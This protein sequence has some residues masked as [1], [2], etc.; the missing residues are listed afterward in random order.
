MT[1]IKRNRFIFP[2]LLILF[3]IGFLSACSSN[4]E[5]DSDAS[6]DVATND[7]ENGFVEAE[8][9]QASSGEVANVEEGEQSEDLQ[10]SERMVIYNGDISIEV[11]DFNDARIHIQDEVDQLGGFVVESSVYQQGSENDRQNGMLIVRIPQEYFHSF[12]NDLET[13]SS[14]VLEKATSGNDVTEEFVDLE[15]QLRSKETVEERLLAFLA[16]ANNTEDLLS[17]S[18][19]LSDVQEDI[20]RIKGR[21]LYLQNHVELSTVTIHIQERSINV[22]SLQDQESL[23]TLQHAQSLFMDTINVIIS[24]FSRAFVLFVG[25]SPVVIPLAVIGISVFIFY[26]RRKNNQETDEL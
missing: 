11:N 9:E 25:L 7:S 24:V 10:S 1:R 15:S 22:S 13:T 14:K 2:S 12:L 5:S 17:I 6:Y 8:D 4:N 26:K 16:E 20:E 19:D 23:N 21:K 18:N 3:F